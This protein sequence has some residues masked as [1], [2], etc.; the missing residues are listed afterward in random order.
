MATSCDVTWR[1]VPLPH[2][3][4]KYRTDL[5]SYLLNYANDLYLHHNTISWRK[6]FSGILVK[7]IYIMAINNVT[8]RHF[9]YIS[10]T[11][12]PKIR[13]FV[14]N[15]CLNGVN[16]FIFAP[17]HNITNINNSWSFDKNLIRWRHFMTSYIPTLLMGV[18]YRTFSGG[19]CAR[20]CA[21]NEASYWI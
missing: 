9:L 21:T 6:I 15:F 5:N 11:C 16:D 3:P 4:W 19:Q 20:M 13:R 7:I 1:Y 10:P 8:W 18:L 14:H 12:W 17:P 2:Y